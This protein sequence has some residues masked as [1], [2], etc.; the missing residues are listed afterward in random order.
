MVPTTA[1]G[2]AVRCF[3]MTLS[4]CVLP[5]VLSAADPVT[6]QPTGLRI[7]VK[8]GRSAVGEDA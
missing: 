7:E 2:R 6:S 5:M 8:L 4:F 1:T 3:V